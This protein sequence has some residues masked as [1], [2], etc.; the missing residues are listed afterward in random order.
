MQNV[1]E[2]VL[3]KRK[4]KYRIHVGWVAF[5]EGFRIRK[6]KIIEATVEKF[7][8]LLRSPGIS[9]ERVASGCISA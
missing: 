1:E 6:G 2:G 3:A 7:R 5:R 8:V 4:L 9:L